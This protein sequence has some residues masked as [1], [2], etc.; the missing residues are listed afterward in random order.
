MTVEKDSRLKNHSALTQNFRLLIPHAKVFFSSQ[1][2]RNLLL[3]Y[4]NINLKGFLLTDKV[5]SDLYGS[6]TELNVSVIKC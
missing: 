3:K 6:F 5:V 1:L 4:N 2:A